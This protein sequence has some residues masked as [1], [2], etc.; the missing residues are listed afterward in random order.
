MSVMDVPMIYISDIVG[1]DKLHELIKT[2]GGCRIYLPKKAF[3]YEQQCRAYR[4]AISIGYSHNDALDHVAKTFNRS[5]RTISNH[6][7]VGLFDDNK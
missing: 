7:T 4:H 3:E 1:E 6:F 2:H 5:V